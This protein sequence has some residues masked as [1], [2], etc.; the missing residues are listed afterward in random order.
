[1][2]D[3]SIDDI[4]LQPTLNLI[5][6][7]G[8]VKDAR[9]EPESLVDRRQ[10][11]QLASRTGGGFGVSGPGQ[12]ARARFTMGDETALL[13]TTI[14]DKYPKAHGLFYKLRPI[15]LVSLPTLFQNSLT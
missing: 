12:L 11:W 13:A 5:P 8:D 2:P 3:W 14:L 1:M 6:G 4:D 7:L 10:L 9:C 15:F